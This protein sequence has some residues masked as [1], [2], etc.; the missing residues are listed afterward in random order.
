MIGN[1][2]IKIVYS[3]KQFAMGLQEFLHL[4]IL[5]GGFQCG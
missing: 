3:H 2:L 4:I 5:Y 1:T